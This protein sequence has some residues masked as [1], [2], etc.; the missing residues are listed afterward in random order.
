M[1]HYLI[2]GP[3]LLSSAIMFAPAAQAKDIMYLLQSRA[4]MEETRAPSPVPYRYTMY[5]NLSEHDSDGPR[6]VQAEVRVDPS[7]PAGSRTRIVTSSPRHRKVLTDFLSEI[8]NPKT[9][10]A[11]LA[12]D[13]WCTSIHDNEDVDLSTY[14]VVS[15]TDTEAVLKPNLDILSDMLLRKD[16]NDTDKFKR[17]MK[18]KLMNDRVEGHI[19]V[20][21]R[22]GGTKGFKVGMT[23]SATL[24]TI[25]KFKTID[26][27]Q[28]CAVAPNGYRYKSE[29][30]F[31]MSGGALGETFGT[32]QDVRIADLSP[33]PKR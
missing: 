16:T 14:T 24:K 18:K 27:A 6:D 2:L 29:M 33:L 31:S 28:S 7:K 13:F 21:K 11:A 5:L 25:V 1:K 15:Q 12:D 8:E 9:D 22:N 30:K 10:M 23:R 17:K 4:G 20:S 19:I 3:A 32:I 26:I